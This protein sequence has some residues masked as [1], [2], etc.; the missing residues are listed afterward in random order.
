MSLY[1]FIVQLKKKSNFIPIQKQKQ[2]LQKRS[3]SCREHIQKQMRL[4]TNHKTFLSCYPVTPPLLSQSDISS[5]WATPTPLHPSTATK[6]NAPPCR[7]LEVFTGTLLWKV[8]MGHVLKFKHSNA[9]SLSSF[10]PNEHWL[11]LCVEL[12]GLNFISGNQG[13]QQRWEVTKYKY[14]FEL[15]PALHLQLFTLENKI[16]VYFKCSK[17]GGKKLILLIVIYLLFLFMRMCS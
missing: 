1:L 9:E 10:E 5:S 4:Q 13:E 2:M 12:S 15:V 3:T 6:P 16:S 8:L 11:F 17:V 14:F 7:V